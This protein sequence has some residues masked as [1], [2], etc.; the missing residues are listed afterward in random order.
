[1]TAPAQVAGGVADIPYM[2][3][4]PAILLLSGLGLLGSGCDQ[5]GIEAASAV[6]A[7]RE[8]D[9]KAVGGACRHA[10]RA[11][12]GCFALNRKADRAAVYAGWREMNEYMRE[13]KVESV[14]PQLSDE[15]QVAGKPADD[16]AD[17]ASHAAADAKSGGGKASNKPA[18]KGKKQ[19]S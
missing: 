5:L 12:E 15:A 19:A 16:T 18:A 13:N 11:I 10:A 6:V 7:R 2:P 4:F 14:A 1:M 8:A 9:G 3:R 17:D